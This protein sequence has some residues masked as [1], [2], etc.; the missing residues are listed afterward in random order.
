MKKA[1]FILAFAATTIT[2]SAQQMMSKKGMPIK[3]VSGDYGLLIDADPFLNY[4]GNFFGKTNDNNSPNFSDYGT[5]GV[6]FTLSGRYFLADDRA[7]RGILSLGFSS[8]T[9]NDPNFTDPTKFDETKTS[10]S[11]IG[12][13]AAYEFRRGAGRLVASYGPQIGIFVDG[14]NG[15]IETTDALDANFNTLEEGG[16]TTSFGVGGFLGLEYFFAPKMSVGGLFG[17]NAGLSSTSERTSKVGT[18][19]E[20]VV[21][22]ESSGF[23]FGNTNSSTI[24]LNFYF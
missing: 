10:S 23:F 12:I 20:T 11:V 24:S 16:S 13:G 18:A 9:E 8:L 2:A 22:G 4:A 14:S 5:T 17:I 19:A 3:P 21:Q 6:P 1:I 7:V 15:K